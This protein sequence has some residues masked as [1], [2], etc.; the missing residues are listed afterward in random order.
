M[1]FQS[2]QMKCIKLMTKC[3]LFVDWLD[4]WVSDRG[5]SHWFQDALP[6][7]EINLLHAILASLQGIST[8]Q[9]F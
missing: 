5:Y 6:G 9:S 2:E 7:V 3:M 4:L 8:H 1:F